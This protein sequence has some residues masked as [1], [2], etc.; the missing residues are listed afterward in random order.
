MMPRYKDD[1][2][3]SAE[4]GGILLAKETKELFPNVK[5]VFHTSGLEGALREIVYSLD[6]P[7][8]IKDENRVGD[9]IQMLGL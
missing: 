4:R 5:F 7:V 1:C 9:I 2:E 3:V 8:F 6:V